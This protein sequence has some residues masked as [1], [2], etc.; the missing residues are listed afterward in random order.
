MSLKHWLNWNIIKLDTN[1]LMRPQWRQVDNPILLHI[2]NWCF[3]NKDKLNKR[4]FFFHRNVF[5]Q[6]GRHHGWSTKFKD[7]RQLLDQLAMHVR[8]WMNDLQIKSACIKKKLRTCLTLLNY[9]E[10]SIDIDTAISLIKHW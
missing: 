10:S 6:Q 1:K 5:W 7:T 4:W 9:K 2:S 8:W 3:K